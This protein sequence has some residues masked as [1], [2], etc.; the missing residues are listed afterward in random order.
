MASGQELVIQTVQGV[1][2]ATITSAS[3][4]DA[5]SIDGLRDALFELIDKQDRR[6]LILN[7]A[8]VQHLSSA[9]LAVLLPLQEKYKKAKGRVVLVGV[10]PE[11]M[12]LFEITRLT[13]LLTFAPTEEAAMSLL[14]TFRG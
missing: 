8:K 13:K 12:K 6:K 1:T 7:M 5:A 3:L 14:G 2:V 10:R 11:L 9:A 4:V